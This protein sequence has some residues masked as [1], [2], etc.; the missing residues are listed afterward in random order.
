[1]VA[2][3]LEA[4]LPNGQPN[5]KAIKVISG[6]GTLPALGTADLVTCSYCLT[7]IPPWKAALEVMVA[8]VA[9][10]GSL[11]LIDFTRREDMPGHWSQRLNTWW[12]AHDGVYFDDAHTRALK[13]HK[14]LATVWYHEA[15]GRV[16]FTP[17]QAT[18]YLWTGVKK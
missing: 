10:G 8:L 16:P 18:H 14:D 11:S 5:S 4:Y 15:E 6:T 7:M 9:K 17:F 13:Q 2:N 12:F 3:L 1:M